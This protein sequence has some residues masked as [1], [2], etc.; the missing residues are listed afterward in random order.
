[1]GMVCSI[2]GGE[3]QAR[4]RTTGETVV[5]LLCLTCMETAVDTGWEPGQL[6]TLPQRPQ[7]HAPG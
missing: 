2:H 5:L 3:A 4:Y 6:I 1:M 7:E